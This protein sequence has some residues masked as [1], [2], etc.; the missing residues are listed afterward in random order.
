LNGI[1]APKLAD[2]WQIVGRLGWGG[3]LIWG[4]GV[5]KWVGVVYLNGFAEWVAK[6]K[7]QENGTWER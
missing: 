5:F 6:R 7:W 4:G 3:V 2:C 1:D